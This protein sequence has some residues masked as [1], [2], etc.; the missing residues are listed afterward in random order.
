MTVL[1]S[2]FCGLVQRFGEAFT[3]G[4]NARTGI[5]APVSP[6][7]ASIYLS[8]AELEVAARPVRV[9]YVR[10]D[11]PTALNDSVSWDG[12]ALSVKRVVKVRFRGVTVVKVLVLA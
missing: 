11:D 6:G 2:R 5:F 9:A 10:F 3:V 7:Q 1:Q 12:M 4:G 8:S